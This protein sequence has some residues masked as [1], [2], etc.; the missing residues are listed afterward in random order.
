MP[1]GRILIV[2]DNIDNLELVRFLLENAGYQVYAA[3]N[4]LQGLDLAR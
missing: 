2:E 1:Q 3:F 4:W